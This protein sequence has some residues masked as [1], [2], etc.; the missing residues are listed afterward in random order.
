MSALRPRGLVSM[1]TA[2]ADWPEPPGEPPDGDCL[3]PRTLP[4]LSPLSLS[5]PPKGKN[6]GKSGLSVAGPD[7][8]ARPGRSCL[9]LT[10]HPFHPFHQVALV[11]PSRRSAYSRICTSFPMSREGTVWVRPGS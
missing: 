1:S 8:R 2:S 4:L 11:V 9:P 3:H 10:P 5:V 7:F 6:V